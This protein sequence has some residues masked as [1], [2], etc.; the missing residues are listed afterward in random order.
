MAE[1]RKSFGTRSVEVLRK[2]GV[3]VIPTDTIYGICGSAMKSDVVERVYS[4]RERDKSKPMIV[5]VDSERALKKFGVRINKRGY[6]VLKSVWPGKVSVVL[7]VGSEKYSYLHRGTKSI[8]FRVPADESLVL[9]LKKTGPLVAPSANK[10]NE[11]PAVSVK[12]ARAYFGDKIDLYVDKGARKSVP[13]T[14]CA[15]RGNK[16]VVLREGATKVL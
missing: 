15:L 10:E 11:K 13:S 7:S 2:G 9:F 12:E 5:L 4:L 3:A 14:L 8:A 6:S 16:L 1:I